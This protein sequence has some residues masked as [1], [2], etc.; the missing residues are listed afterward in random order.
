MKKLFFIF[1]LVLFTGCNSNNSMVVEGTND[2]ENKAC[3]LVK[4][5]SLS[6][7]SIS[8]YSEIECEFI[9]EKM[10]DN[11]IPISIKHKDYPN[12][13]NK[14][15]VIPEKNIFF[16]INNK[17]IFVKQGSEFNEITPEEAENY[18]KQ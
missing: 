6:K 9:N 5:F 15:L 7:G 13:D 16:D 3:E 8:D 1:I 12:I 10:E 17:K 2:R 18:S 11:S 14:V 4:E